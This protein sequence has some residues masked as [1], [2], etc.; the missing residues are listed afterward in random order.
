[1]STAKCFPLRWTSFFTLFSPVRLTVNLYSILFQCR[2]SGVLR[3]F[4]KTYAACRILLAKR[5]ELWYTDS[6]K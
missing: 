6:D 3:I 2:E 4:S 1:M 5:R